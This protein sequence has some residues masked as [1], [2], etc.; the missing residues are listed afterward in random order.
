MI[1]GSVGGT[2][3]VGQ[4][5]VNEGS[6]RPGATH[7][8]ALLP[9]PFA[10][11]AS[12]ADIGAQ[13]AALIVS[14]AREQKESARAARAT[15]ERAQATAD[16]KE[17]SAM[18]DQADAK[19]LAGLAEGGAKVAA[20]GIGIGS[21]GKSKAWTGLAQVIEASGKVG[22]TFK[23]HDADMAGLEEK[24]WGQIST[25]EGRAV[26]DAS[27]LEKDAKEML[28]RAISYYKEYLTAKSDTQRA[29]L[30]RA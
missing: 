5:A 3:S 20:G 17:L 2:S 13:I 4:C 23:N 28:D 21:V 8:E 18:E 25:R 7:P 9:Q 1:C 10:E 19:L 27:D 29:T 15:A 6:Q 16:K 24:R 22:S 14:V 30:L 11:L 26:G 12:N